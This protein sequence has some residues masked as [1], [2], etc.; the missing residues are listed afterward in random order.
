MSDPI[1]VMIFLPV[2][3][4]YNYYYLCRNRIP[5]ISSSIY[6]SLILDSGLGL[7][8]G[9]EWLWVFSPK[10]I[11]V[12]GSSVSTQYSWQ[13]NNHSHS[14]LSWRECS[15]AICFTSLEK[16]FGGIIQ[17]CGARTYS[18]SR[19]RM[20]KIFLDHLQWRAV[21]FPPSAYGSSSISHILS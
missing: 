16:G 8:S 1:F 20:W 12:E 13:R 2:E 15:S 17:I 6:V 3:S 9:Q 5:T 7:G 10:P 11:A 19:E 18:S 14:F 21:L 4:M